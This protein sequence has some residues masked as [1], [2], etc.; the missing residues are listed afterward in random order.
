[1]NPY[2]K[3]HFQTQSL[4]GE[5][6]AQGYSASTSDF[7]A[8]LDVSP[9]IHSDLSNSEHELIRYLENRMLPLS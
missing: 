7:D 4:L 3:R 8:F 5:Q 6:P 1:M 2:A 9:L